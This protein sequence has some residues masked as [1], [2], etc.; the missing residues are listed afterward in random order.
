MQITLIKKI[1]ILNNLILTLFDHHAPIKECLITKPRAPWLNENLKIFMK[2]RDEAL[3]KFKRTKLYLDW[4]AY[5][6]LRNFTVA[7]IRKEKKK[8]LDSLNGNSRKTW[9]TLK[10]FNICT[11]KNYEIPQNLSNPNDINNYFAT[12]LQNKSNCTNKINFYANNSFKDNLKFNFKLTNMSTVHKILNNIKTNATGVDEISPLMLKYC[13]PYI[14]KYITHIV[15]C[16]IEISYFPDQWKISVGKPLP[17]TT[18]PSSFSELRIISIL[19]ALSKIFE[20]I[21][22]EQMYEYCIEN[23]IIPNA[24]CGFRKGYDTSVA[25][26]N[27][28]DDIFRAHDKKMNTILVLLDF[29]KAFDTVNHD[30]L[31]AKLQ[32]YGYSNESCML[33][34]SYLTN[35]FQSVCCNNT[36]SDRAAIA[37]GVPQGSILGPLLFLIYTSDLLKSL[38]FC[39]IQAFADDTQIYICFDTEDFKEIEFCVNE[40]LKLLCQF[41][42]DHNLK[43][44]PDKSQVMAF[45]NKKNTELIK[46]NFN[47]SINNSKLSFVDSIKNLGVIIDTQLRFK[48][49]LK[50]LIQKSFFALKVLYS[51]RHILNKSL[52]KSLCETL[53]LSN[54]TYC[55]YIYGFCL[56]LESKN[57]IQ[58]VQNACVRFICGLRKFDHISHL[59]RDLGWLKMNERRLLHFSCFLMKTLNN[60]CAPNSIK[61]RLIFRN[62][63]HNVN[64]RNVK[65][66]TMPLHTTAI[67]K[68]SFSYNA[69]MQY[70]LIPQSYLT[71]S[72]ANFKQKYKTFLF[73]RIN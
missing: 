34:K 64:I 50:K 23:A 5:K 31:L 73:N 39:K 68:R 60:P 32:Y 51:N 18:N 59:Y 69:V 26:I 42:E 21:L 6:N 16:C 27:V 45:G 56:D 44:N 25:L 20:R 12:Y 62:A 54:F 46:N 29:S 35:R 38:N 63:I 58:R 33:I 71:L 43:L 53:V 36:F 66:L 8:Y 40:D 2:Q 67:F 52:R 70:N 72:L 22:H 49:H 24:Q 65:K 9:A 37:S 47:I 11:S 3:Q 28:L 15:N 17:K 10:S 48:E 55:D 30:L 57:R 19:P 61:E 7:A 1:L 4:V 13:S 41:S 14:D